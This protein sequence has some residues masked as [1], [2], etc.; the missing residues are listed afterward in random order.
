MD[1]KLIEDIWED[2]PKSIEE[3][4]KLSLYSILLVLGGYIS[5]GIGTLHFLLTMIEKFEYTRIFYFIINLI[6]GF[7]L[8][9][10]YHRIN[11]KTKKWA[12][13]GSIFSLILIGLGGIVGGLAGII[14]LLGAILAILAT[15]DKSFDL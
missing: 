7:G 2:S 4:E 6:F 10:S 13:L 12:L 1:T 9:L 5:I 8:L 15:Y 11:V 14:G 3:L